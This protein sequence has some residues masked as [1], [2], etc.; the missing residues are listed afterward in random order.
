MEN[1]IENMYKNCPITE[2]NLNINER[3]LEIT[4]CVGNCTSLDPKK[5]NVTINS[6][7]IF[8]NGAFYKAAE[9]SDVPLTLNYGVTCRNIDE[10]LFIDDNTQKG[11]LIV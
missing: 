10:L 3:I 2:L 9:D 1:S 11:F 5:S 8:F 7:P 4:T 6:T